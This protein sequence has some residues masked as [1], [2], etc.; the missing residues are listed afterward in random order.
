M[1]ESMLPNFEAAAR[2]ALS[3][4]HQRLGFAL[5]MVTRVEGD[6]WIV[7]QAEDHGYNVTDGTV[8]RWADSFCA[9]MVDG[10][11]PRI[12]ARS[13]DIPAFA[14]APMARQVTIGAYVGVPLTGPDGVLFGT[15]CA[16]DP[17]AQPE[18]IAQEQQL[19]EV[20]AAL[21]SAL[22]HT[23]MQLA[24]ESRRAERAQTEALS[25]ALTG[26]F[27]RRG[28]AQLL[29]GEE[30][31]CRR[32]G[33]PASVFVI[34]LDDLKVVNDSCGHFAGDELIARAGSVLR[35]VARSQDV[36]ARVGG[37]EFALLA[38]ECDRS[39]SELLANRI[40]EA[41]AESGIM[42]SM[43]RAMRDPA[44]G[45]QHAWEEAD[46]A[47]YAAKRTSHDAN[48]AAQQPLAADGGGSHEPPRLKPDVGSV[49][50]RT[51]DHER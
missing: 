9:R 7:L 22:L 51:T 20:I 19:V 44:R 14:S 3:F 37:D 21:L 16:I 40:S 5:W 31:R 1:N 43:G 41:L 32:F 50:I 6:D 49:P 11:G 36:V 4:L 18:S 23:E 8:F 17:T 29:E 26:L 15:L 42:A 45:V 30:N 28:W 48:R 33:H 47:M 27:N 13:N 38:V 46:R 10:R 12:A 25:D 24:V 34:D 2:H 35:A 39:G